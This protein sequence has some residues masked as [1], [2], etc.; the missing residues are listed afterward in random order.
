MDQ[1]KLIK[2]L[3]ALG[4]EVNRPTNQILFYIYDDGSVEKR[5]VVE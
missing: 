3:D 1:K 4:R 2:T 5:F